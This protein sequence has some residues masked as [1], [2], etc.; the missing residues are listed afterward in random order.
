VVL[1][2]QWE[3]LTRAMVAW[4]VTVWLYLVLVSW[5]ML[6]AN[7]ERVRRIAEQEDRGAVV[8]LVIMSVA[9]LVSLAAIVLEL[10]DARTLSATRRMVHYAF[11]G[12]TVLGSWF[13]LATL[14]TFHYARTYYRSPPGLRALQFPDGEAHPDYWDFLYF[15][16]TIAV[17]A[18]TSDIAVMSRAMRKIVLAQSV[19]S[20]LF[21]VAIIGLSINIAAGL[22]GT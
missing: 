21:N 2:P 19:L 8:I 5:L 13:L 10:A 9:A 4:N 22:L 17:A 12:A 1:P 7:H 14:F 15:S 6:R 11:T 18:Q 16:Y 20:F 3:A